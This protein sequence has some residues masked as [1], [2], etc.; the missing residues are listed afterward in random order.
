MTC[1]GC[2]RSAAHPRERGSFPHLSCHLSE[3]PR[4]DPKSTT[5]HPA[6]HSPGPRPRPAPA[7]P[8]SRDQRQHK[9]LNKAPRS[10]PRHMHRRP[11]KHVAEDPAPTGR[12]H[13]F[14]LPRAPPVPDRH[15]WGPMPMQAPTHRR[16]PVNHGQ[17]NPGTAQPAV[18]NAAK[19]ARNAIRSSKPKSAAT[20]TFS[21]GLPHP[22]RGVYSKRCMINALSFCS[23]S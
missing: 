1:H 12:L 18:E 19:L 10:G 9:Y 22:Y 21:P 15:A 23:R 11:G 7:P 6:P 3:R 2:A 14:A 5:A 16:M 20:L 8:Q 13:L 4:R 17:Q